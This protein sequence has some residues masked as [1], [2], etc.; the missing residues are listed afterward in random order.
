M[1]IAVDSTGRVEPA[2]LQLGA[3]GAANALNAVSSALSRMR[4]APAKERGQP[5]CELMRM[6]VNFTP[7]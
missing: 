1:Q 3:G 6:Q 5:V 2:S 7:R 4:F